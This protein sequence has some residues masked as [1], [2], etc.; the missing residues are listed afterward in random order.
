MRCWSSYERAGRVIGSPHHSLSLAHTILRV[1]SE[2]GPLG[3]VADPRLF[4]LLISPAQR[5]GLIGP[6]PQALI[7]RPKTFLV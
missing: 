3:G 5:E 7:E 2:G 1:S 6:L 4:R